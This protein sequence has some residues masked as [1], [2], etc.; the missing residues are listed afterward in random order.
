VKK[1]FYQFVLSIAKFYFKCFFHHRVY[2][3]EHLYRGGGILAGN[4]TSFFDPPIVAISCPEEVHFL[5]KEPL[6]RHFIFGRI[7]RALN[8]HPVSGDASDISVFKLISSLLLEGKKVVLFPEGTRS[9]TGEL[10]EIKPG[11]GLLI[12]RTKTAIIPIYIDGAFEAW[13]RD[14]RFPKLFGKTA[15]V[16]GTPIRAEEFASLEKRQAQVAIAERLT[17]AIRDL[18]SW[19]RKGAV[20]TPP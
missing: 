14:R 11:I 10:G 8:S 17:Q 2:G 13:G 4:H 7:I 12:M 16:F 20:G 6:F 3:R 5:A 9:L 1:L 18:K 19:Y 15:C